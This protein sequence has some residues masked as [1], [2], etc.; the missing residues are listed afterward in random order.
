MFF[1]GRKM[2]TD[3]TVAEYLSL[4]LK[5]QS[6]STF[7]GVPGNHLGPCISEFEKKGIKWIGGTNEMNIGYAADAYARKNGFSAV[8]VTYG[9]GALSMLNPISG[10]YVEDVP[11]LVINAAPKYDQQ[12]SLRDINL[13]TSHMSDR[14]TSNVDAYNA[15]T[16]IAVKIN[17]AKL[18]PSIID[19]AIT[20]CLTESKPVY[21]EISEN[22]FSEICTAPV[23]TLSDL[24]RLYNKSNA[25]AAAKATLD[26]IQSI[27]SNGQLKYPKGPVL[28]LGHEITSFGL[29]QKIIDIIERFQVPYSTTVMG[30]GV[31]SESNLYF[32]GVYSG[33]SSIGGT[34]D[35]F[36]DK[37]RCR[38]GIGAW[39]TSKNLGNSRAIGDDWVMSK[40]NSVSVGT[41]YYPNV[42]LGD[43]VK[44]L[45]ICLEENKKELGQLLQKNKPLQSIEWTVDESKGFCYDNMFSNLNQW[46]WKSKVK[47]TSI[48]ETAPGLGLHLISDAGFSLIGS[49]NIYQHLPGR[50]HSQ[51]SW[52]SIGYSLGALTGLQYA[53]KDKPDQREGSHP[54]FRMVCIGD[55]SFQETAQSLS[56][57]IRSQSNAII[58]IMNNENFYGIEQM[59]VDPTFY[60]NEGAPGDSYNHVQPWRYSEL[61]KVFQTNQETPVII[62]GNIVDSNE[63][64]IE[65]LNGFSSTLQS[66][67]QPHVRVVQCKFNQKDYPQGMDYKVHPKL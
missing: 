11:I 36:E 14:Q 54:E 51:A 19:A 61:I 38:I 66:S 45:A 17:N 7:F 31:I 49:Q 26:L 43:Y 20:T 34:K 44:E 35:F 24:G 12:L 27:N 15:V 57:I 30:K 48:D 37:E 6:L 65:T 42:G 52:L 55:G 32:K 39:S 41:L 47:P 5:E 1:R 3:I 63:N 59:L 62:E 8:G 46:L 60:S 33:G 29:Q 21:L 9:V 23:G 4:R 25:K 58:F 56:D 16:G 53:L 67:K 13:L 64:L 18:A 40:K 50:F 2:S 22:V 28:W 10:A